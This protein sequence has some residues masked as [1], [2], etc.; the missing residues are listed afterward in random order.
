[1]EEPFDICN[2]DGVENESDKLL[3]GK[4]LELRTG[5]SAVEGVCAEMLKAGF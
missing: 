1:V 3:C 5:F 2:I 4:G